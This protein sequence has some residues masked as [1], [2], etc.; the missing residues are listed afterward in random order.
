MKTTLLLSLLSF[1]VIS[2][3][4]QSFKCGNTALSNAR[5]TENTNARVGV[6]TIP[7]DQTILIPVVVHVVTNPSNPNS[8]SDAN[9][10]AA[11]KL[12]NEDFSRLNVDKV[13]TPADFE[14]LAAN[15]RVQFYLAN[16]DPN[17]NATTGIT[18]T[19]LNLPYTKPYLTED[20]IKTTIYGTLTLGRY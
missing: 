7:D 19:T 2:S 10:C 12:L 4:G 3:Y 18:R 11:I 14:P 20:D 8:V 5:V 17:N 9:V 16:K 13:N 1:F 6:T 15:S